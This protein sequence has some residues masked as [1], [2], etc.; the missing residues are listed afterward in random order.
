MSIYLYLDF[1]LRYVVQHLIKEVPLHNAH[2]IFSIVAAFG[3]D[4]LISH[5]FGQI[6]VTKVM[7]PNGL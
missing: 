5:I 4:G 3:K 6:T 1:V 2:N 7:E